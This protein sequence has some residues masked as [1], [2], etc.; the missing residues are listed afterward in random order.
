MH[1]YSK[2]ITSLKF[3]GQLVTTPIQWIHVC[4]VT[5]NILGTYKDTCYL[6]LRTLNISTISSHHDRDVAIFATGNHT[7]GAPSTEVFCIYTAHMQLYQLEIQ[8][9]KN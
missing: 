8:L 3:A 5:V 4:I 6:P 7:E 9:F 2:H 1:V